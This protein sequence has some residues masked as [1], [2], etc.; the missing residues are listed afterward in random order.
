MVPLSG[1]TVGDEEHSGR[2]LKKRKPG[3]GWKARKSE[4]GSELS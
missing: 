1:E 4:R 3:L 2:R